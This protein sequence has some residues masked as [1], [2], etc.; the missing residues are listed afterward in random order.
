M[1]FLQ[2]RLLYL[3]SGF[4]AIKMKVLCWQVFDMIGGCCILFLRERGRN[5]EN[6]S[7]FTKDEKHARHLHTKNTKN[8]SMGQMYKWNLALNCAIWL[9]TLIWTPETSEHLLY[10]GYSESSASSLIMLAHD[11][12]GGCWWYGSRDGTF[13][14]IF[15][16]I[17]S[18]WGLTWKCRR[19]EGMKLNSHMRKKW[20]PLAF[21]DTC[22]TFMETK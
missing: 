20:H 7:I 19:S 17:L 9:D 6:I 10:E 4:N 12:R 18:L 16:Y 11:I 1:K 13:P 8:T 3:D 2:R 14:P 15:P 5:L 22:W 21:T